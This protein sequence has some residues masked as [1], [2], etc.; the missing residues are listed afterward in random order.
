VTLSRKGAKSR[1]HGRKLRSSGTKAGTRVGQIPEP[2]TALE[3]ELEARTQEL[4]EARTL[5]AQSVE[6]EAATSDVL[7]VISS[8]P[9]ELAPV[10]QAMLENAVRICEAGFGTLYTYDGSGFRAAAFHNAPRAFIEARTRE[11]VIHPPP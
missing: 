10:F 11:P 7:R 8:S 2:H 4:A 9:G 5:L 3:K 1:T 6:R